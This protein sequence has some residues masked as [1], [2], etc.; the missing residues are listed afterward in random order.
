MAAVC[1]VKLGDH[2]KNL[3]ILLHPRSP[4]MII[5]SGLLALPGERDFRRASLRIR[6]ERVTEIAEGLEPTSGEEVVDA[7]GLQVFPGAIDPHVHFDEPGFTSREDFRHGSSEAARGGVTTVI[8]M[9]CTSLPP[10]INLAALE[11]KLAH[12]SKSALVDYA[13]YGGVSGH[14]AEESLAGRMAELAPKV[15]GFKCYFISGMESF[16]RVTHED[17]ARIV[18]EG[19]R[20]GRPILLHAEDLDYVTSATARIKAAR[21]KAKALWSDYADSRPEAAELVAVASALALASGRERWLHIVHVGT[22]AAAE[23][24]HRAGASCETCAHYL[25]FG[26]EDF[27]DKGAALKTAPVVKGRAER[28]R[29]W[30]LLSDG[31]IDFLASDHAP[32]SREEKETGDIWTAYGGIPGVG[33]G[34]PYLYSEGLVRGRLTL[35]RFLEASSQAAAARYGLSARKGALTPG[36]DADLVLVDPSGTT[37]MAGERLLSKGRITPFEGMVLAG[38]IVSTYVRGRLVYD[39]RDIVVEP[40]Y[41]RYLTWGYA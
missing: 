6:S 7:S 8:D 13:L 18:S 26:R 11:N 15:V 33:S 9:P 5:R 38:S 29:L 3:A 21:G 30:R 40:G 12:I 24:A 10:V 1:G 32:S 16:T 25:A 19:Q 36:K 39:G 37:K 34:F 20:L 31:T 23:L 17:F 2:E 14:A 35:A 28:D 4:S 41:G 27:A 22:A